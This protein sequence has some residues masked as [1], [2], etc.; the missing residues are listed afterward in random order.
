MLIRFLACVRVSKITTDEPCCIPRRRY[1]GGSLV[2]LCRCPCEK[3]V[4]ESEGKRGKGVRGRAG[5]MGAA[6][7]E[8]SEIHQ[9]RKWEVESGKWEPGSGKWKVGRR[10][11][12][13]GM[14]LGLVHKR[15][16]GEWEP[17]S[18]I[19][20]WHWDLHHVYTYIYIYIHP[21]TH[22][23]EYGLPATGG[24][25]RGRHPRVRGSG[26]RRKATQRKQRTQRTQQKQEGEAK[27]TC[28]ALSPS[29]GKLDE[30]KQ[31]QRRRG[32]EKA[33]GER[34]KEKGERAGLGGLVRCPLPTSAS[35]GKVVDSTVALAVAA[36]SSSARGHSQAKMSLH[37]ATERERRASADGQAIFSPAEF[38]A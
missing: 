13:V 17:L 24:Q 33:K 18:G 4:R 11:W 14:R 8:R 28:A 12:E 2:A 6:P 16:D 34:R 5:K 23:D 21:L 35:Q 36:V 37:K 20:S 30:G 19:L 29:G 3:E 27:A 25:G 32:K 38:A 26:S 7:G 31:A 15:R 10:K 9:A 1:E 22:T